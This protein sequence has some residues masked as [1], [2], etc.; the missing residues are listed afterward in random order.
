[1]SQHLFSSSR[2]DHVGS[3]HHTAAVPPPS[4][5]STS[6]STA[7]VADGRSASLDKKAK[8]SFDSPPSGS[9]SP[10]AKPG[11]EKDEKSAKNKAKKLPPKEE[12]VRTAL[13]WLVDELVTDTEYL[14]Y[15]GLSLR[16]HIHH[17]LAGAFHDPTLFVRCSESEV[18]REHA[19][20][21]RPFL[22]GYYK[23]LRFVSIN[24]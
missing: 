19:S 21:L 14:K 5:S 18:C 15:G 11:L 2:R 6:I 16:D 9:S 23:S 24:L 8:N 7:E 12:E 4:S 13:A 17:Q 20:W 1:M 3:S 22:D 10:A